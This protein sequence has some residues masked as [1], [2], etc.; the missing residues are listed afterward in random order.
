MLRR[1]I[2]GLLAAVL[3]A[4]LLLDARADFG[5]NEPTLFPGSF[6]T[7]QTLREGEYFFAPPPWGW[8]AYGAAPRLTLG[9]DYP[10]LLFGYPAAW[11]RYRFYDSGRLSSA[12]EL[13]GVL[14]TQTRDDDRQTD[15]RVRQKGYQAWAHLNN[16]VRIS[17]RWRIHVYAGAN[18]ADEQD[19]LPL[20]ASNFTPSYY[21][22]HF[23]LDSGAA[24]EYRLST[25]VR[26]YVS[27]SSGNTFYFIDQVAM[28]SLA[29]WSFLFAPW[30]DSRRAILRNLRFDLNALWVRVPDADYQ[31]S[32][33]LPLYP[34]VYW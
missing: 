16:T 8:F 29:T 6:P 24:V 3:L 33:P 22:R 26:M 15:F 2:W 5:A 20:G 9:L 10:A 7:A 34:T 19:Y 31:A 21:S 25:R 11:A 32:L 4:A 30:T 18:Y 1:R 12:I 17:E 28:K 14:W 23:N 27:Y 13:Y